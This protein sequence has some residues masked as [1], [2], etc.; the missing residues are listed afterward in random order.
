MRREDVAT[1]MA[2]RRRNGWRRLKE[3]VRPL[4]KMPT[5]DEFVHQKEGLF[6]EIAWGF[7]ELSH[8]IQDCHSFQLGD[9]SMWLLPLI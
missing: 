7:A 8:Q 3:L 2:A 1:K 5:T 6:V 9:M 4:V